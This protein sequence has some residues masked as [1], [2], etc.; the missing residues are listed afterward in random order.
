[1]TKAA[2]EHYHARMQRVLD[3]ID[4]HPDTDLR[5]DVLSGIA[6]FSKH[7]FH[8]Q[9][10][11]TFGL[12]V[13]RYVQLV[14]LKR[15]SYHLAF[16]ETD[17]VTGVAMDAGYEAPDAF[18]RAFR[19]RVG[20]SPSAFRKT[21]DWAPWHAAFAPLTHARSKH[22]TTHSFNDV[23][24][25]DF[26]AT[27]V[28]LMEHKGDPARVYETVQRFIAWRRAAGLGRDAAAT[29]TVF[30][31]D[32][33]AT[34]PEDFRLDVCASTDRPIAPNAAGVE[35]GLIPAGRC[36]VLRVIGGAEDLE[37]PALFL[38]RDW[39]PAS[40]EEVRDFPLFCQRITLYPDVPE[41]ETVTDLFLPLV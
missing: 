7:H 19:Q 6:A 26:P 14:R 30:H 2:L 24:V 5:L 1:M 13:H 21:P 35:A 3:H 38:Y 16:R 39:L 20:Q 29:F 12:S 18:A 34:P 36:A 33:R 37:A 8:R 22:M 27:P 25:R 23:T 28:A 31:S 15:A 9:F 40:G 17:T 4:R 11:A 10:T 32:P 41:Q